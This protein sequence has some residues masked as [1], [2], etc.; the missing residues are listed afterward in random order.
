MLNR[1]QLLK[2]VGQFELAAQSSKEQFDRLTLIYG[3]NGRD[4]TT[5]SAILLSLMSGDRT[6]ITE[7][8]RLGAVDPP[9]IVIK[10]FGFKD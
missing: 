6:L 2:G 8:K 4:K 1:F 9:H 3:E 5:L 7:R 10:T